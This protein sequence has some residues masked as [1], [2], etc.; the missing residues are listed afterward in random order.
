[1]ADTQRRLGS[2][3]LVVDAGAD[4]DLRRVGADLSARGIDR[5]MVEGGGLTNTA[6]LTAEVVDQLDLVVAPFFVGDPLAQRFVGAGSFPWSVQ[7]RATLADVRQ[8]GDVVL[9]RYALSPRFGD[10]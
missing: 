6:F 3:A 2:R 10:A 5:L 4:V 8:I 9:M 7:H 1:V